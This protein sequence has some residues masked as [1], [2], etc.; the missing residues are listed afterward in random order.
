MRHV[1][2][3][4]GSF[5][6]AH[7][8]HRALSLEALKRLELDAVWWLI[9]PQNPLKSTRETADFATRCREAAQIS[10]HPRIRIC[11]DEARFRTR[12]TVDSLTRLRQRYPRVRFVWLMGADNL[13]QLPRWKQ[14]K[15]L[16]KRVPIAVFDRAPHSHRVL[17]GQAA[18]L[19]QPYRTHHPARLKHADAP[20]WC[21]VFQRKW[22][23]SSTLIRKNTWRI[24]Q[25]DA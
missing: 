14:W 25:N 20:Q 8:G 24:P 17:R 15:T 7:S 4:G 19:L 10:R 22:A 16:T 2:L 6:P 13:A 12:Y 18:T 11:R 3:L 1:G 23:I 5:N 21:Y 9:S